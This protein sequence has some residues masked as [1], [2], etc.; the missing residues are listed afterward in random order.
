MSER[1]AGVVDPTE[2]VR[3]MVGHQE[4]QKIRDA[5]AGGSILTFARGQRS[6]NQGEKS[7]INE[8]VAIDKKQSRAVWTIHRV[9][10]KQPRFRGADGASIMSVWPGEFVLVLST[11]V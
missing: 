7:A 6:R 4:P 11:S 9:N 2:V 1:Q 10:I 5:P 3:P 8:S